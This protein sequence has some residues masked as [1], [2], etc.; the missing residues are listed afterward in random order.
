MAEQVE[1]QTSEIGKLKKSTGIAIFLLAVCAW[2]LGAIREDLEKQTELL[3]Q[4][5]TFYASHT[6]SKEALMKDVEAQDS[7]ASS[8]LK[9]IH[10]QEHKQ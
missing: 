9:S 1:D 7:F 8:V 2:Q 5:A 10:N 3:S 6:L 4:V